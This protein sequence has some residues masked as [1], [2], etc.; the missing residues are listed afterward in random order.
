MQ[1]LGTGN[2]L[3]KRSAYL[4]CGGFSKF[5][6]HPCTMNEDVDLGIKL[7][8]L[9][10]ILL[11]HDAYMVHSQALDGRPPLDVRAED[12]LFNRFMILKVT[13]AHGTFK[14]LRLVTLFLFVETISGAWAVLRSGRFAD[15]FACLSGRT[16][17]MVKIVESLIG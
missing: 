17:A 13:A 5:F 3:V 7:T 8:N 16:K 12:D 6:L 9:G 2:S 11:C 1:W 10:Q 15:F 4:G 14:S